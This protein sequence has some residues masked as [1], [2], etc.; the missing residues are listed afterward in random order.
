MINNFF[1]SRLKTQIYA[2]QSNNL[3]TFFF[4]LGRS[5]HEA[6]NSFV[7]P[8][9]CDRLRKRKC[10]AD[11]ELDALLSPSYYQRLLPLITDDLILPNLTALKTDVMRK[12]ENEI[13][14]AKS[15]LSKD[16]SETYFNPTAIYQKNLIGSQVDTQDKV[17]CNK[18]K[19][20]PSKTK[21][22]SFS[23][24]SIIGKK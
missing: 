22:I 10:F 13:F 1:S 21:N 6:S 3:K 7:L 8:I 4:F 23:V 14:F 11:K 19:Y 24:E 20:V 9:I 12:Q 18:Q 2:K 5:Y 16:N 15:S 17:P